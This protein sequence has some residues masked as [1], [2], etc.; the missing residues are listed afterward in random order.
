MLCPLFY[1][2]T[3]L[4]RLVVHVG[5]RAFTWVFGR[6][7]VFV[8]V[9][10]ILGPSAFVHGELSIVFI[11]SAVHGVAQVAEFAVAEQFFNR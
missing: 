5:G 2:S 6:Q 11:G 9:E 7:R 4:A 8:T 10:V 1:F 3:D